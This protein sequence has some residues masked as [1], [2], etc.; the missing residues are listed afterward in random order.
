MAA[1]KIPAWVFGHLFEYQAWEDVTLATRERIQQGM[2]VLQVAE[3]EISIVLPLYNEADRLLHTLSSL[4]Q[5]LI[6]D[7]IPTELV[8]INDGSEDGTVELLHAIGLTCHSHPQR[9]GIPQARQTGLELAKGNIILQ[10]D[11]DSLYPPYWGLGF[12]E[13]LAQEEVALVYGGHAILPES[14][15]RKWRYFIYESLR[16]NLY[17]LR[18]WHRPY[19]NVLGF[20]MAFR[21]EDALQYGS[22]EHDQLG[23]DDGAMAKSLMKIGRL[24]FLEGEESQ[25]WTSD[26]RLK[27]DGGLWPAF[28]KRV[29]KEGG[30]LSEYLKG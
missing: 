17:D 19:L 28:W 10:A 22:Y 20:N 25:V 13:Q 26:R 7:Q 12:M 21:R 2:Q 14:L 18:R 27:K 23:S 1:F 5:L 15:R 4:S 11:G 16:E 24:V 29:Q 6:P 9:L 8:V 30:R 3:P